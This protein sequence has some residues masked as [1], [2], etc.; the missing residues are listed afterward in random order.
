MLYCTLKSI[1]NGNKDEVIQPKFVFSVKDELAATAEDNISSFWE[2]RERRRLWEVRRSWTDERVY[3]NWIKK[4]AVRSLG[5]AK[6]SL[7]SIV[8]SPDPPALTGFTGVLIIEFK[9]VYLPTEAA[10]KK[11]VKVR[12]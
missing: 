4:N 2:H 5:V 3:S 12:L 9:E 7:I 10:L 6:V 1:W 8:L 11:A